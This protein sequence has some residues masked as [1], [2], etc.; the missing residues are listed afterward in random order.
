LHGNACQL[1]PGPDADLAKYLIVDDD[2][3]VAPEV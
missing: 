3:A 2:L 1:D